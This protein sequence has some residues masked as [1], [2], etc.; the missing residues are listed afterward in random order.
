MRSST[1]ADCSSQNAATG[2]SHQRCTTGHDDTL[3]EDESR[4]RRGGAAHILGMCRR[5]VVG[6]GVC[7]YPIL[8]PFS[9][10]SGVGD[11]SWA[12]QVR[13]PDI[14]SVFD[15]Q[16]CRRL[17][18]GFAGT[19][20]RTAKG[21]EKTCRKSNPQLS[22]SPHRVRLRGGYRDYPSRVAPQLEKIGPSLGHR[23]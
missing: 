10:T 19:S 14:N 20:L 16:R 15:H 23:R 3:D 1:P 7:V 21:R 6:F 17:V 22:G 12:S 13:V 9:I 8:L 2:R 18:L 5:L 4:G 11:S